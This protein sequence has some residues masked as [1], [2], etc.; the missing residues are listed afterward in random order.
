VRKEHTQ[1]LELITLVGCRCT[2]T[3]SYPRRMLSLFVFF[4]KTNTSNILYE[5]TIN[6]LSLFIHCYT[7]SPCQRTSLRNSVLPNRSALLGCPRPVAQ[8][9]CFNHYRFRLERL[10]RQLTFFQ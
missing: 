6:R 4:K 8:A 2:T 10:P 7:F 1:L 5:L 3:Y 9:S